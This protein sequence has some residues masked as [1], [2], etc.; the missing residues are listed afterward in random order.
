MYYNLEY[1]SCPICLQ[2]T[3]LSHI[4]REVLRLDQAVIYSVEPVLSDL[5][6]GAHNSLNACVSL[7]QCKSD[8]E[9]C[10]S[11]LYHLCTVLINQSLN[12]KCF[13][14]E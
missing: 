5:C 12:L 8:T 10:R 13:I 11:F 3:L 4:V 2:S 7:I 1:K 6:K 14:I 9:S